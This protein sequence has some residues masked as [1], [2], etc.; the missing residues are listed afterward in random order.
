MSAT[1]NLD[2]AKR[3]DVVCR[4][5]DTFSMSITMT[6]SLGQPMDVS[7]HSFKMQVRPYDLHGNSDSAEATIEILT[8]E[9][10][11]INSDVEEGN[12]IDVVID[13]ATMGNIDS[14]LYVYDFQSDL[15]GV[16][17]TWLYG[18]FKV[19]EDITI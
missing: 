11:D 8:S 5:G 19:N 3:V 16:V 10:I 17:T 1:I 13:A 18:T 4:K 2:I 7:S 6:D 15:S 12:V 14:G 9:G